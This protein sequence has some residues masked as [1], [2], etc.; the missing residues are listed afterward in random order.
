MW[1]PDSNG[2]AFEIPDAAFDAYTSLI[3]EAE[4]ALANAEAQRDLEAGYRRAATETEAEAAALLQRAAEF[5]PRGVTVQVGGWN[6]KRVPGKTGRREVN[7]DAI[8][9]HAERLPSRLLPRES[10][11]TKWPT[12]A[13][14]DK[15]ADALDP[16]VL[17]DLIL[18]PNP[19]PDTI[20]LTKRE[21]A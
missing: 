18:H 6:T 20:K 1:I 17:A 8:E 16:D 21:A 14:I 15:A 12:V 2:E 11:V 13:D 4:Q 5:I 3:A 9:E 10:T 7:R 19:V